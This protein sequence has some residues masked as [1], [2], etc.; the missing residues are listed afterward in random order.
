LN[1]GAACY[2]AGLAADIRGG[3]AIAAAAI[4]GGAATATLARWVACSGDLS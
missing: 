1:A 3:V 2:V 4:D